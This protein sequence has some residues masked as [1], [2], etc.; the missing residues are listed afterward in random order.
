MLT[1]TSLKLKLCAAK[2]NA[3]VSLEDNPQTERKYLQEIYLIKGLLSKIYQKQKQKNP[4]KTHKKEKSDFK[5]GPKPL[6]DTS[7]RRYTDGKE[8]YEK[9]SRS[10]VIREI[11]IKTMR[12]YH[13]PI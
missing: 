2:H 8:V 7:P 6:M 9:I 10:Y 11:Q 12:Y 4:L 13:T 3:R 1:I 5:N